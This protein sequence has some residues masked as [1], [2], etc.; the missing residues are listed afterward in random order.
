MRMGPLEEI[1]PTSSAAGSFRVT[2]RSKR[3][4]LSA[5]DSTACTSVV[6]RIQFS[7][8]GEYSAKVH[9]L[10]REEWTKELTDLVADV[11][12]SQSGHGDSEHVSSGSLGEVAK[13]AWDKVR[14]RSVVPLCD[15]YG[16]LQLCTVPRGVPRCPH[17]SSSWTEGR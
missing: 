16:T 6:T 9:F 7:P 12:D 1:V 3:H 10:T 11:A 5:Y 13:P 2:P 14:R 17:P 8:T 4:A 15:V